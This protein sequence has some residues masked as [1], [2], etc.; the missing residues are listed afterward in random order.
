MPGKVIY[1]L[2]VPHIFACHFSLDTFAF[3]SATFLD[4]WNSIFCLSPFGL[5]YPGSKGQVQ[6]KWPRGQR[7]GLPV[8]AICQSNINHWRCREEERAALWKQLSGMHVCTWNTRMCRNSGITCELYHEN[9]QKYEYPRWDHGVWM[10]LMFSPK[11]ASSR[12][13]VFCTSLQNT[14]WLI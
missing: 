6:R 11:C 3:I 12:Y 14:M 7:V 8:T 1:H 5:T 2:I 9:S 4:S 10:N 13:L